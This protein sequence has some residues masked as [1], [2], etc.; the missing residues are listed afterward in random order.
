MASEALTTVW[1]VRLRRAS[2]VQTIKNA[3]WYI[4]VSKLGVALWTVKKPSWHV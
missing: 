3:V 4:R 1:K 2:D